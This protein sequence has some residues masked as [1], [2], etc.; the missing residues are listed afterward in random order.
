VAKEEIG[1]FKSESSVGFVSKNGTMR[2]AVSDSTASEVSTEVTQL[3]LDWEAGDQEAMESLIPLVYEDLHLRARGFLRRERAGHTLQPT[4]LVNEAYLR[5]VDQKRVRWHNRAQFFGVAAKMMR[6]ILVDH[7][8]KRH[9]A[10][11]GD[12]LSVLPLDEAAA[13]PYQRD[14]DLV[15]LDDALQILADLDVRAC[16]VVELRFFGGLSIDEAA[17]VLEVSPATVK[18]D[19]S[20]ARAWLYREVSR[21][22]A[23]GS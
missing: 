7:A 15:A 10:K 9:A 5:L 6:R 12:G 4:A 19:W 2:F 14:A 8:R 17:Q 13:S 22:E 16:R 3:L 21:K 23:D 20:K 18:N 1:Y 11:R